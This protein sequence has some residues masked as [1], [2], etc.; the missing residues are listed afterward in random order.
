MILK[1]AYNSIKLMKFG[2]IISELVF[3]GLF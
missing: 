2:Y 3:I 1:D